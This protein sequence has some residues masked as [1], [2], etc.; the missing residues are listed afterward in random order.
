MAVEITDGTLKGKVVSLLNY[1][2]IIDSLPHIESGETELFTWNPRDSY[3]EITFKK[4]FNKTPILLISLNG[5]ASYWSE[6]LG[7]VISLT[8]TGAKICI[9]N[10]SANASNGKVQWLA[11]EQ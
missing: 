1:F 3:K 8:T 10:T 4:T 9:W 6:C 2:N 5:H 7:T 11:I